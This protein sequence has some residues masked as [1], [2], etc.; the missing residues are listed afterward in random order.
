MEKITR[1]NALLD[2][3]NRYI[4]EIQELDGFHYDASNRDSIVCAVDSIFL[5]GKEKWTCYNSINVKYKRLRKFDQVKYVNMLSKQ[6]HFILD[7]IFVLFGVVHPK[8]SELEMVYTVPNNNVAV[9]LSDLAVCHQHALNYR[10]DFSNDDIKCLFTISKVLSVNYDVERYKLT[11]ISFLSYG[12]ANGKSATLI[13]KD[14][15]DNELDTFFRLKLPEFD[16][17]YLPKKFYPIFTYLGYLVSAFNLLY[18]EEQNRY[19][20]ENEHSDDLL[21]SRCWID[22]AFFANI[23]G[24]QN[25]FD[26]DFFFKMYGLIGLLKSTDD[27]LSLNFNVFSD[28]TFNKIRNNSPYEYNKIIPS[29]AYHLKN[30]FE[31]TVHGIYSENKSTLMTYSVEERIVFKENML[32]TK[33]SLI[34]HS[35]QVELAKDQILA[36]FPFVNIN[37]REMENETFKDINEFNNFLKQ[38]KSFFIFSIFQ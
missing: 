19:E 30:C 29:C 37:D 38:F 16:N 14:Y 27:D 34:Q 12:I 2:T 1:W 9:L 4:K 7:N 32:I 35:V 6:F 33:T 22:H 15:F 31:E 21:L 20:L 25:Y 17:N 5:H 3:V 23:E 11:D 18:I 8:S 13:E 24:R 36:P 26:K 10:Y 28:N